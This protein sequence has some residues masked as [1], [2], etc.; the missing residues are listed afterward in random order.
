MKPAFKVILVSSVIFVIGAALLEFNFNI[1]GW[2]ITMLGAGGIIL[3]PTAID[4]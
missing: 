1:L 3:G 2:A 4:L